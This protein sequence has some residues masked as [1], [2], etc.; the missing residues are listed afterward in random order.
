MTKYLDAASAVGNAHSHQMDIISAGYVAIL[1]K[2]W[3]ALNELAERQRKLGRT[4]APASS[5][6]LPVLVEVR[7]ELD[8]CS[9][10]AG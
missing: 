8:Q 4:L 6:V 5:K 1:Q 2:D 9:Q 3:K 7:K 10:D